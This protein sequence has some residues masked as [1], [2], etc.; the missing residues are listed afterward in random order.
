[1]LSAFSCPPCA[2]NCLKWHVT[3]SSTYCL[4]LHD[5]Q[6][7]P[8]G[9]YEELR[10]LAH[11]ERMR[12]PG[13][14]DLAK[15]VMEV[16][17]G[18]AVPEHLSDLW[19][20]PEKDF[21]AGCIQDA[22]WFWA[23]YLLP[24]SGLPAGDQN[25]L[26]EWLHC[27]IDVASFFKR[28]TGEFGGV[29]YDTADPPQYEER[30]HRM[31]AEHTSFANEEVTNLLRVGAVRR[32]AVKPRVV[33][34]LAVASNSKGKLRLV[35]DARYINL[36]CDPETLVYDSLRIFHRGIGVG[37]KLVSLDHKSGY[38]HWP[39]SEASKTYM[40]FKWDGQYYEF[41]C[42]PFGWSPACLAYQTASSVVAGFLRQA[43][44][45]G[46]VY[47]DDFAF[48]IL[49]SANE[50]EQRRIVWLV[51]AVMY[52][53][54]FVV[55]LTKSSLVPGT[56]LVILG[57]GV[58][59]VAQRF[60]V[61][62]DKLQRILQSLRE[63]AQAKSVTLQALRSLVGK[64]QALSLAVPSVSVYLQRAYQVIAEAAK[65]G[66]RIVKIGESLRADLEDLR[67]LD[68]WCGLSKWRSETHMRMETDASGK[69]GWGA[70]LW[71]GYGGAALTAHGVFNAEQMELDIMVKEAWAVLFGL[72]SFGHEIRDC[73]LDL[74]TDNEI[75]RF[76]LLKGSVH[77]EI[78]REIAR[79]L[80]RWQI[81]HNV[82]ICVY[83]VT[84]VDNIV[85]D[86]LSRVGL[87]AP[88]PR[89]YQ[90]LALAD[91]AF[92]RL[93]AAVAT[94]FTVD[95]CASASNRKLERYV[96]PPV[97]KDDGAL[98][99]N[100]FLW[101][102]EP[103]EFLYCFPPW[104]LI[105]PL[106]RHLRLSGAR[107]VLLVPNAPWEQWYGAVV[108]GASRVFVL[109]THSEADAVVDLKRFK[110]DVQRKPSY[111]PATARLMGAGLLAVVFDFTGCSPY[112]AA[113]GGCVGYA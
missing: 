24:R 61:P 96:A 92:S 36:F 13:L 82:K 44:I 20:R 55:S 48:S 70:C 21:E 49:A 17:E 94:P 25:R 56:T 26:R 76:T 86:T 89:T 39:L 32:A 30:N 102:P 2:H 64:V 84:T 42:L 38:H 57:F 5:S 75:V 110:A 99:K 31:T 77:Y 87:T 65:K 60:F 109:T 71:R 95:A 68:K 103:H 29:L 67:A 19:V 107:G 51:M 15:A 91:W 35:Y 54:G 58:D 73:F 33:M 101:T 8:A 83:R 112:V 108:A 113:S 111:S 78:M 3:E 16:A 43:R 47:L 7:Q 90:E 34:P 59:T 41:E 105:S 104:P 98:A 97:L 18:G 52:L 37:D 28:Y 63:T 27:G 106:W 81:E 22:A 10:E 66:W 1:M 80:V 45:H 85:T 11:E 14:R 23:E 72:E 88:D 9:G 69:V 79:W 53:A 100:V 12:S 74:F 50:A 93:C 4:F 40:G 6:S 46:L 62:E